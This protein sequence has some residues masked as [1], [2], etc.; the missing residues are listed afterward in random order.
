MLWT[1]TIASSPDRALGPMLRDLTKLM[2]AVNASGW[3]SSKVDGYAR[4]IEIERPVGGWHP[5]GHVLLCFQNRMTRTEARAFAL[6]L[7]DRYLAAANRLGISASTM[8]QH[9]R[10]VPVEQIDVAVRYVTKQHVLTKPKADGSA[11]LSSLTMDAYTRGDADALDL[12]HE[13]EGATYGKQL[14][15]TAGIC[16]PS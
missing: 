8:G 13:V 14:W 11:T 4:V 6:T 12:L 2:T 9:V 1:Y 5:H 10:L 15:R 7:R 16:K 3:L